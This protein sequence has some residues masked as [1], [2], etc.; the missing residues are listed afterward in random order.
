MKVLYRVQRIICMGI[1]P[2]VQYQLTFFLAKLT[3][4][5]MSTYWYA[6]PKYVY[7][8]KFESEENTKCTTRVNHLLYLKAILCC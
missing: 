6:L 4:T 1:D 2:F 8:G 7:Y 5:V 3:C